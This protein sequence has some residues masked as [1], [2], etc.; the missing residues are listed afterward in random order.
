MIPLRITRIASLYGMIKKMDCINFLNR[1]IKA[2]MFDMDGLLLDTE[3]ISASTF[4]IACRAFGFDPDMQ[5]YAR[6]I[7]TTWEMTREVL[8]AAY[9]PGF[10]AAYDFW[11]KL[12]REETMCKPVPL[13]TGV[14]D[15]ILFLD[16]KGVRKVVVTS[17]RQADASRQLGNSSLLFILNLLSAVTRYPG[18]NRTRRYT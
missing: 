12:Y 5:T 9:G 16:V 14:L 1:N 11:R 3:S 2:V 10:H 15:F 6:C 18:V 8:T 13:K 17:T 7:G 4:Q